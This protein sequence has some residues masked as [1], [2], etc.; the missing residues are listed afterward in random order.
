MSTCW[1]YLLGL[2]I[3]HHVAPPERILA[4]SEC[5][6]NCTLSEDARNDD[7]YWTADDI[8]PE[9]VVNNSLLHALPDELVLSHV[10]PRVLEDCTAREICLYRLVSTRW[11]EIVSSTPHWKRLEPLLLG[12]DR[13]P[14]WYGHG[15]DLDT[16]MN[17]PTYL[18]AEWHREDHYRTLYETWY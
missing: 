11:R 2:F 15:V 10:L 4:E 18:V 1:A 3:V 14:P 6:V 5:I 9:D 17:M 12:T 16:L 7:D 13:A 8:D